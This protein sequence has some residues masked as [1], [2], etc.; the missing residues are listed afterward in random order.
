MD[1]DEAV[2]LIKL[3]AAVESWSF[4]TNHRMPDYLYEKIDL[5]MERLEKRLMVIPTKTD[6]D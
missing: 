2:E 5:A 4:A 1:K 6:E 3:L